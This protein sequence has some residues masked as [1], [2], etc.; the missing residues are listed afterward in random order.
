MNF[1][2][3]KEICS[4]TLVVGEKTSATFLEGNLQLSPK[5]FLSICMFKLFIVP[6]KIVT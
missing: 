6:R 5:V 1:A 2:S 3:L 4:H